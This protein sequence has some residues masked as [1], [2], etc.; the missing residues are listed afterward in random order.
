MAAFASIALL[1]LVAVALLPYVLPRLSA[2]MAPVSFF[3][4]L[5]LGAAANHFTQNL[6]IYLRSFK[7]EPFLGQSLAVAAVN[8]L[9]AAILIPRMGMAGAAMG[10]CTAMCG[11]GLPYALAVFQRA[12]RGHSSRREPATPERRTA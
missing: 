7:R 12:R 6:A 9:F 4:L 1:A 10:Y 3:A 11:V 8:L 5:V 2:R